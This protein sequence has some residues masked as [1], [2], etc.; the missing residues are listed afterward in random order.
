MAASAI[1][2]SSAAVIAPATPT[3]PATCPSATTGMPPPIS[4]SPGR[5][6]NEATA[7]PSDSIAA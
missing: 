6:A 3:A 1:R 7:A 2:R 5:V 4:A